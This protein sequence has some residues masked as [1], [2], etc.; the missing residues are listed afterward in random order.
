MRKVFSLQ[1]TVTG[2]AR[3]DKAD[4][5]NNQLADCKSL[6]LPAGRVNWS[7]ILLGSRRRRKNV[8]MAFFIL[9]AK[10]FVF[11]IAGGKTVGLSIGYVTVYA[12]TRELFTPERHAT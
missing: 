5:S 10:H 2:G 4:A 8:V 11:G 7:L 9:R 6:A 3:E 1:R 12:S